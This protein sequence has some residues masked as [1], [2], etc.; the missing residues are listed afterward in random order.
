MYKG[1]LTHSLHCSEFVE[2]TLFILRLHDAVSVG[3]EQHALQP[4]ALAVVGV[5]A[6][7]AVAHAR[8]NHTIV[9]V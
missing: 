5:R 4:L 1:P 9:F 6:F 2:L 7:R 8:V 3:S